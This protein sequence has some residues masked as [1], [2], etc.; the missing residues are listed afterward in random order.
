MASTKTA[1]CN[2]GP[3]CSHVDQ[4]A[5]FG[6]SF[7]HALAPMTSG[8]AIGGGNSVGKNAA[9]RPVRDLGPLTREGIEDV[10]ART[11][12]NIP[13]SSKSTLLDELHRLTRG[14][15]LLVG[16]YLQEISLGASVDSLTNR[17]PGLE[18]FLR[19]WWKDQVTL[20][21]QRGE[22]A[23]FEK[24]ASVV[25]GLLACAL[26]PLRRDEILQLTAEDQ[27]T[28]SNLEAVL[29]SLS[30]LVIGDGDQLPYAFGHPEF[31]RY[32]SESR[33]TEDERATFGSR[34]LAWGRETIR[35]LAEGELPPQRVPIYLVRHYGAH[36]EQSKPEETP[37][38]LTA[39]WRNAWYV[40]EGE[41]Y[42]GFLADVGRVLIVARKL[43]QRSA[44]L[45][46]IAP[47]VGVKCAARCI[48]TRFAVAEP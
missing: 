46:A 5:A 15:P 12:P 13:S 23:L 18:A 1:G 29:P 11:T 32:Y 26:G 44:G 31:A 36:L 24:T 35:R 9:S 6:S 19:D 42:R 10:I 8:M 37:G 22:Q 21:R 2:R 7:P 14:D 17:P 27:L 41:A 47:L 30:R 16:L 20:W 40:H 43:N 48:K 3:I 25:L 28:S 33:L 39:G 45:D 34:F 4:P 38:L